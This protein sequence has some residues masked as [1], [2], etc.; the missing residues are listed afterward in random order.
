MIPA[1]PVLVFWY[2]GKFP[3]ANICRVFSEAK[4]PVW[5]IFLRDMVGNGQKKSGA[6]SP[7][8]MMLLLPKRKTV[9][10]TEYI[11]TPESFLVNAWEYSRNRNGQS[12]TF[13]RTTPF[14]SAI[15]S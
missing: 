10:N 14:S 15:F 9:F 11:I 4:V 5:D 1:F 8:R 6:G 3:T 13:Q 7:Y 12:R 2:Y